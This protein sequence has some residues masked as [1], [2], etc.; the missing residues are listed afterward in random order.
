VR[1]PGQTA[2]RDIAGPADLTDLRNVV[3][4]LPL[5]VESGSGKQAQSEAD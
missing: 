5:F 3:P 2:R 1:R 4:D